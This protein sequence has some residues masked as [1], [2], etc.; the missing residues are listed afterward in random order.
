VLLTLLSEVTPSINITFS[1]IVSLISLCVVLILAFRK[2][3]RED[4]QTTSQRLKKLE[5]KSAD[6]DQLHT[7][8]VQAREQLAQVLKRMEAEVDRRCTA[9]ERDTAKVEQMRLDM[10]SMQEQLKR[11]PGMEV[12]L[13][14]LHK[15]LTHFLAAK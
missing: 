8:Q 14:D 7:G 13:D 5:A 2:E 12:K 6:H 10:A 1:G 11:L 9:M 3:S 15:M 4:G